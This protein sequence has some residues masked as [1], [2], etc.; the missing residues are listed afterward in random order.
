MKLEFTCIF[1]LVYFSKG[2]YIITKKYTIIILFQQQQC[3]I[4]QYVKGGIKYYY[5]AS[6]TIFFAKVNGS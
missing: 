4:L 2:H 1:S 5:V 3:T 6:F